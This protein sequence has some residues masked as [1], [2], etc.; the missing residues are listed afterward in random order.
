MNLCR[1]GARLR[2][3]AT[4]SFGRFAIAGLVT[5]SVIAACTGTAGSSGGV[6]T[7]ASSAPGNTAAPSASPADPRTAMLDYSQC[8]RDHGVDVPDPVFVEGDGGGGGATSGN[9][10]T[11]QGT[12]PKE[13]PGFKA[14]DD[15]CRHFLANI[16][17]DLNGKPMSAEEQVAFL[18]FAS[19]MRDHGI[20]MADPT[21]EGGGVSIQIGSDDASGDAG[22]KIDP[23]SPAFQAAQDACQHFLSDAGLKGPGGPAVSSSETAAP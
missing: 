13:Q 14:A 9:T 17:R 3:L 6:V 18:H 16:T 8:M 21:F 22:P 20:D 10:T 4:A 19:C 2:Q 5:A 1:A 12:N 7:L 23:K 15:A 11:G